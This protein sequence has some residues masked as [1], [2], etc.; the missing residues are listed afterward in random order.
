M[1]PLDGI[2][3]LDF[4]TLLP[5]PLATLMFAEAGAQVIKIER[6]PIG[7]EQRA[8]ADQLGDDSATFAVLN[9]GKR[10]V[11]IDLKSA[12]A[13]RRLQPLIKSAD[14]LIEQFRPGVMDRLGLGYEAL[15]AVN[16][17]LV[18]CSITGYGQ[19]GPNRDKAAHDLNYVAESGLL[20]RVNANGGGPAL[21][22]ALV[23]DIGAGTYPAVINVLMAL[24]RRTRDGE[25]CH[26]DISM[27][28]NLLPF[29]YSTL[30]I[31]FGLEHW[32]TPS[33]ELTTGA[34]PRYNIYATSD[35][36]YVAAAPV[37]DRFWL[38]FCDVIGLESALRDDNA[39][40]QAT[41]KGVA[42]AI[43]SRDSTYWRGAFEGRD[44]CATLVA[45]IQEAVADPHYR[46]RGAFAHRVRT[47]GREIPAIPMPLD[48]GLRGTPGAQDYPRL[49]EGNALLDGF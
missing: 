17:R 16:P 29:M 45:S 36:R 13:V 18:Y 3:V 9:R 49:G 11:T 23:A 40:A 28:D 41:I 4:S 43:A 47:A 25:G 8:Y 24:L 1:Q 32:A 2:R 38:N 20:S 37:E 30:A 22:P 5:G 26:I 6:P 46:A 33:S 15:H 39:D 10:S 12:G 44:V 31:G 48:P 19:F 14:V 27:H 21:P 42:R 7:D 34:S 35:G